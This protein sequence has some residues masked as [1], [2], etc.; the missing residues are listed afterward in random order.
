M[1][2]RRFLAPAARSGNGHGYLTQ[3]QRPLPEVAD[4]PEVIDRI[5]SATSTCDEPESPSDAWVDAESELAAERNR[6]RVLRRAEA[7]RLDRK[8]I[9]I[10]NRMVD[11][12]RRAKLQHVSISHELH[13]MRKMLARGNEQ[14]TVTRLEQVEALLDGVLNAEAA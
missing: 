14:A 12:Q 2:A 10:E 7:A 5:R 8:N 1:P 13:V 4:E 3:P 6:L 11:A 9:T